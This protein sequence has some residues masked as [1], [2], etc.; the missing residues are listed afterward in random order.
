MIK[1]GKKDQETK[2]LKD[3]AE[4]HRKIHDGMK[5]ILAMPMLAAE[6]QA[7]TEAMRAEREAA[8]EYWMRHSGYW[9]PYHYHN[10]YRRW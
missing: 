3:S 9:D 5:S 7:M 4:I 6:K 8:Y 1:S 2:G 10:P